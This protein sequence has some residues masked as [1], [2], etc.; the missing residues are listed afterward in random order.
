VIS[1]VLSANGITK[2]AISAKFLLARKGV[3]HWLFTLFEEPQFD[4]LD[5]PALGLPLLQTQ[6][7]P[8]SLFVFWLFSEQQGQFIQEI[9]KRV[10]FD[11]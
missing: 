4:G 3:A 2:L 8:D 10:E 11:G 7:E 5:Q 9:L 6:R 1:I